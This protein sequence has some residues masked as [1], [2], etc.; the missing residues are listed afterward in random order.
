M[1]FRSWGGI[2]LPN[3]KGN[4]VS[5]GVKY[6]KTKRLLVPGDKRR[7]VFEQLAKV[8]PRNRGSLESNPRF[9]DCKSSVLTMHYATEPHSRRSAPG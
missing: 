5:G 2:V 1:L 3:F 9:L 8:G 4:P 7:H 6:T